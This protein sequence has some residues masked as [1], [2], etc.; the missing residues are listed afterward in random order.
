MLNEA[1]TPVDETAGKADG[2]ARSIMAMHTPY[3]VCVCVCVECGS[4][5]IACVCVCVE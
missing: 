1:T 3:S 5:S 4:M 2:T